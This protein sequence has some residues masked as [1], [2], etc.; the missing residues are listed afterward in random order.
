MINSH[1]VE[2]IL[3]RTFSLKDIKIIPKYIK[4]IPF[5]IFLACPWKR[6]IIKVI[7]GDY[8]NLSKI[9]K[10]VSLA[11]DGWLGIPYYQQF[12]EFPRHIKLYQTKIGNYF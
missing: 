2:I 12:V 4:I 11:R 8:K 1:D 10:I 7:P 6:S 5:F 9:I 3:Y